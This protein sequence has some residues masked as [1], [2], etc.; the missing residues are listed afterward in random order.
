MAAL[1]ALA[2]WSTAVQGA[3]CS[4]N[5][6]AR[7]TLRSRTLDPDV[8]VWNNKAL[9]ISYASGIW[10]GT[11]ALLAHAILSSPGTIAVTIAC[12]SRA[13]RPKNALVVQDAIAV[14]IL[15]G[16][17]R[18]RTGWVASDDVHAVRRIGGK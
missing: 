12:E 17:H 16:P 14:R 15:S 9:M 10:P 3:V 4:V 5:R 2:I 6:G 7:V 8:F 13:I 18:G 1:V 11:K